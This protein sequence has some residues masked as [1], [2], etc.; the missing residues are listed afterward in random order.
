MPCTKRRQSRS[1]T[2]PRGQARTNRVGDDLPAVEACP[3]RRAPCGARAGASVRWPAGLLPPARPSTRGS[4]RRRSPSRLPRRGGVDGGGS[5]ACAPARRS[6]S[7]SLRVSRGSTI[8]SSSRTAAR[9]RARRR[10]PTASAGRSARPG[11]QVVIDLAAA[12][13]SVSLARSLVDLCTK[14]PVRSLRNR[15]TLGSTSRSERLT[16]N[17]RWCSD[18]KSC[19]AS[20]A[21]AASAC[22]AS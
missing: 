17:L 12:D 10:C 16:R 9:C 5:T 19:R 4:A 14:P 1:S 6:A 7:V 3:S 18:S 11:P 22:P 8:S 20:R 2:W 21:A 15:F 13:L